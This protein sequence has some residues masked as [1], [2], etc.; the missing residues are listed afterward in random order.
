[1]TAVQITQ[2]PLKSPAAKQSQKQE[3][4]KPT[5]GARETSGSGPC[6][7]PGLGEGEPELE[8]LQGLWLWRGRRG[9]PRDHPLWHKPEPQP[10]EVLL[11]AFSAS[12]PAPCSLPDQSCPGDSEPGLQGTG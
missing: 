2:P 11:A 10:A 6:G 7:G 5:Y 4:P 8:R 12:L 1:M 9:P 3:E